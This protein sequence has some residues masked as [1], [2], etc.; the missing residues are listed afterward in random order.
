M[1]KRAL[2][3]VLTLALCLGMLPATA[4]AE[5]DPDPAP[6]SQE[7]TTQA[8]PAEQDVA[9]EKQDPEEQGEEIV[10]VA[11]VG[12]TSYATLKEALD[13]AKN[14]GTVKLLTNASLG[15][16]DQEDVYTLG[17][18]E[19]LTIDLAGKT[20]SGSF[21]I[22]AKSGDNYTV[23]NASLTMNDSSGDN[24]GQLNGW[25]RVFEDQNGSCSNTLTVNGGTYQYTGKQNNTAYQDAKATVCNVMGGTVIITGGV[26]KSYSSG[27][28]AIFVDN[29]VKSTFSG[30]T[31]EGIKAGVDYIVACLKDGYC[32]EQNGNRIAYAS[33]RYDQRTEDT[34]T[35]EKCTPHSFVD[36]NEQ[37]NCTYCNAVNPDVAAADTVA[38]VGDAQFKTLAEAIAAANNTEIEVRLVK[39]VAENV[40]VSGGTVTIDLNGHTWNADTNSTSAAYTPLTVESSSV[41][42]KSGTVDQGSSGGTASY[43]IVVEGGSLT[44]GEDMLVMG[45]PLNNSNCIPAIVLESG[46]LN[47]AEG[48]TLIYGLSVPFD[49]KLSD[50][51]PD[52]T[53]FV[54]C[55]Y[56]ATDGVKLGDGYV[57]DVYTT[58]ASAEN[59]AVVAHKHSITTGNTCACGFTCSHKEINKDNGQC[60]VCG[61]QMAF[62]TD[63]QCFYDS[64]VDAVREVLYKDATTITLLRDVETGVSADKNKPLA[65]DLKDYCFSGDLTIKSGTVTVFGSERSHLDGTLTSNVVLPAEFKGRVETL[66]AVSWKVTVEPGCAGRVG[67]LSLY[68]YQNISEKYQLAGGSFETIKFGGGAWTVNSIRLGDI[69]KPGY[70]FES[71]STSQD[72]TLYYNEQITSSNATIT[73]VKVVLCEQHEYENGF[74]KYC[75]EECPHTTVEN[76]Q[77]TICGLAMVATVTADGETAY[78]SALQTALN[79]AADGAVVKPLEDV[80]AD[81]VTISS[82]ITLDLNGKVI[83]ADLTVTNAGA[84][85]TDSVGNG[86]IKKLTVAEGMTVASLLEEGFLFKNSSGRWVTDLTVTELNYSSIAPIPIRLGTMKDSYDVVYRAEDKNII[87]LE[88]FAPES[89]EGFGEY[90]LFLELRIKSSDGT[91]VLGSGSTSGV[92]LD[93]DN[94]RAVFSLDGFL[95]SW[96]AGTYQCTIES[97]RYRPSQ[98]D[99]YTLTGQTFTVNVLQSGTEAAVETGISDSYFDQ[100]DTF[101]YGERITVRA[102]FDPTGERPAA[103]FSMTP[104]TE[105]QCAV[106]NEKGE[107]ISE[108]KTVESSTWLDVLTTDLGV[109]THNLTVRYL[110]GNNQEGATVPFT[111]TVNPCEITELALDET[112]LAY[113]GAAQT[114]GVAA[115][116]AGRLTLTADDYDVRG[117]V[118]TEVG[119]YKLTV[120]GKGNYTG[121]LTGEYT[122]A[123]AAAPETEHGTMT[124]SNNHAATY[125]MEIPALPAL[126]AGTYGAVSYALGEVDLSQGYY[127]KETGAKVA[128]GKLFL[129]INANPVETTGSIGTV[130]IKVT[131]DNYEDFFLTIDVSAT[132]K[133]VPIG[134]PTLSTT[135]ITYGDK[136]SKVTLSG[137][138]KDGDSAVPGV[139]SWEELDAVLTAGEHQVTWRFVPTDGRTYAET[140]GAVTITVNK[141]APTG[142]PKYT[143]ITTGGKTLE[144]AGLTAEGGTFSVPG[145]VQWVDAD[146]NEMDVST[147]VKAN[148][149]YSWKF[150]PE[151]EENYESLTGSITL[152]AVS[153]SGGGGG[154]GSSS[155][156]SGSAAKTD[157]VTTTVKTDENGNTQTDVKVSDKALSDAKKSGEAVKIPTGVK[158]G[159]DSNSAPVVK[160]DLPKNAGETK[161]EVPVDNVTPGTVAVIV[162][163]DGTEEI[164]SSSKPTEDGLEFTIDG[165]ATI[166]VIDNSKTFVDTG[167]HWA[168]GAIDYISA[169]DLVSGV[170]DKLFAP[171]LTA[172][173]AQLWTI[174]ARMNGE[175]VTGG[176]TWYELPQLWAKKNGV[177]D[178]TDPNGTI[179]RAQLVTMLWRTAGSPTAGSET[180]FTDVPAD[181]YYAQAVA[182]AAANGITTGVGS[183]RFDPEAPCTRAQLATFLYQNM[184]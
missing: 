14:G 27:E 7:V 8:A 173:R 124:V 77:C 66:D 16:N 139:F 74:C 127:D 3:I 176:Q 37:S 125:E 48:V 91:T 13:A 110:G 65:L 68:P 115:V 166:K 42:L 79:A 62:K 171:D 102:M 158:A 106:F 73:N 154:G 40:V 31:F 128:D 161:I 23:S 129:P 147:E 84:K 140:T 164:L 82:P 144:D 168:K 117:N 122:I 141:A 83:R 155:G 94:K 12:E 112:Q 138:L 33:L 49:N 109:G 75:N 116:T 88:V 28:V 71:M 38:K 6:A 9:L 26:F 100:K 25:L 156:S 69:L 19:S 103:T 58:N 47:L 157:D 54:Q 177:S 105:D 114:K 146:G 175:T 21:D 130:T 90:D 44:L 132:N 118:Q 34:L 159:E 96:D 85:L 126:D 120:T 149:A 39:N 92:T 61:Y 172:T 63:N 52:G 170:G 76:N 182:W 59:M 167:D 89:G 46:D 111:V 35:V 20:L 22:G 99:A 93:P 50:Y 178:G 162:H 169:R 180:K 104:P 108:A 55:T 123:K 101:T 119:S 30:G 24:S 121:T 57:P 15:E 4:W 11:Q 67:T 78:Y 81:A 56:D 72:H 150:V 136:L 134:E 32:F 10:P 160:I 137:G 113:T 163:E 98:T 80:T 152:Y 97:V 179:T 45:S 18:G 143:A 51:L 145:T 184:K 53:A 153:H 107:Q 174:L 87:A 17:D 165:S 1:K 148:T 181:S 135:T 36:N 64:L 2:S 29:D 41:T 183:G 43:G 60:V 131:T 86:G 5:Q 70:R 142:A 95:T 151:D 133:I